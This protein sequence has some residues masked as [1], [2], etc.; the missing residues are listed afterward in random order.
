MGR[1]ILLPLDEGVPFVRCALALLRNPL[2]VQVMTRSCLNDLIATWHNQSIPRDRGKPIWKP[3]T[4]YYG[5]DGQVCTSQYFII[6][7]PHGAASLTL[8][9][10]LPPV[11]FTTWGFCAPRVS[12]SAIV[13]MR[14]GP[15]SRSGPG[16]P[17]FDAMIP[18]KQWKAGSCATP[19]IL[20][21]IPST[22]YVVRYDALFCQRGI[23]SC[24]RVC[25]HLIVGFFAA[26]WY[27][28]TG[29]AP[30]DA[31]PL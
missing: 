7:R 20:H 22:E 30:A 29:V 8:K 13:G 6:H 24:R 2:D 18:S 11:S 27:R 3:G 21:R 5:F 19:H 31:C 14:G 25:T 10:R 23:L 17:S 16:R 28:Y 1:P 9:R 26:T 4:F 15:V 12:I